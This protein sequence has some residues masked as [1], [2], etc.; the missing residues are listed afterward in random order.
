MAEDNETD[1]KTKF[2]E[3]QGQT[4]NSPYLIDADRA[5]GIYIW[6][7]SGKRY[8]D[9]I[10]GLAVNNIGH[11][12]PKVIAAIKDQLDKHLHLM[13]YG[14]FIQDSQLKLAEKLNDLLPESLNCSYFVN[15]GTEAN[16]A[17]LK[18][19]KRYT[20]RTELIAFK[21]AYHGSTHGSLSVSGN[22]SKKNRF[23]PLLPDTRHLKFNEVAELTKISEETAAVIIE[24]IQGDAGVRIPDR[25]FMIRLR[26]RCDKTNTLLIFDEVQCGM[27][28]CGH[29]FAF[30]RFGIEPD[31]LTLGKALGGGMPI[32]VFISS[33]EI[34]ASLSTNPSLG[35]ITTFGGHPVIC[36]AAVA[37]LEVLTE[38]SWISE[39]ENKGHHLEE[40]L[41]EHSA[42]KDIRRAGLMLA[43]DLNSEKEVQ[44]VVEGCKE[45]GLIAYW[46]L[47]C[48]N[49]FRLSPPLSITEDE[50]KSAARL[51]VKVLGNL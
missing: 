37:C 23:R 30:E 17:A 48:P 12:H 44:A 35:H 46:F 51:I 32:G 43:V 42:V 24:P 34:M 10:A 19:A 21:G 6:D 38:E 7:K 20:G 36:A 25:E 28:R 2:L 18:L 22:E 31:I 33:K 45:E 4:N 50:I 39:V 9:M 27:G 41:R 49:S 16:E 1:R 15:S 47:S 11:S 13:V 5:E 29:L 3:L 40:L 14:E 26:E 8:V